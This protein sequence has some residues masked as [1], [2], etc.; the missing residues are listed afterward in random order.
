MAIL[1]FGARRGFL[2]RLMLHLQQ[3]QSDAIDVGE[4]PEQLESLASKLRILGVQIRYRLSAL[5]LERWNLISI[6]MFIGAT[7]FINRAERPP[8]TAATT[9]PIIQT[10]PW[11]C[12]FVIEYFFWAS[13][14]YIRRCY[15]NWRLQLLQQHDEMKLKHATI[16]L[17]VIDYKKVNDGLFATMVLRPIFNEIVP[18]AEI[19]T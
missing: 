18:L 10:L 2:K 4:K 14:A 7:I 8:Q 5:F 16:P 1:I 19:E 17:N 13:F 3:Q 6:V 11:H 15:R 12:A 9:T